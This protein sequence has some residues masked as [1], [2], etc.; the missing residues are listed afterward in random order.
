MGL[1]RCTNKICD[2]G[3]VANFTK[4][5]DNRFAFVD[6]AAPKG[7]PRVFTAKISEISPSFVDIY[8]EAFF[9]EQKKLL[10]ICGVGYRKAL[11]FLIKDYLIRLMPEKE[12]EIKEKFLG[13]CINEL[14]GD[15][16]IKVAATRAVWLGNDETHYTRKWVDKDLSD[17]KTL[18]DISAHW[19]EMDLLTKE[20]A[21]EM[22]SRG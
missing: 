10:Q 17:L 21:G 19:I 8:N 6:I 4:V 18:I 3:F 22:N 11:E 7:K 2:L 16:N 1:L 20:Y 12:Q 15:T 9:A 13:N 14:L 5:G